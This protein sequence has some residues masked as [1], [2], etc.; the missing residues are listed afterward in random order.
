MTYRNKIYQ[1]IIGLLLI[2]L[3]SC[4]GGK[5]VAKQ[6]ISSVKEKKEME[7]T[8][9]FIEGNKLKTLGYL[10]EAIAAFSK[11]LEIKENSPAVNYELANLYVFNNKYIKAI[12][13]S[14]KAA[15]LNK[16][17][18]WYQLLYANL[19]MQNQEYAKS[20][21]VIEDLYKNNP[22]NFDILINLA[23]IY[24]TNKKDYSKALKLYNKAEEL[25]GISEEIY[26][27]KEKIYIKLGK[28][29][30][31]IKDLKNLVNA[32]PDNARYVGI[33]AETLMN[34]GKETEALEAYKKLFEIDPDN[35]IA[36]LSYGEFLL[37]TGKI[38][39]AIEEF[40]IGIGNQEVDIQ[41]KIELVIS[42]KN[43]YSKDINSDV[44][45]KLLDKINT[46]HPDR[47]EAFALKAELFL[48]ENKLKEAQSA[49]I[50]VV[51][52]SKD[53]Y[54]IWEQLILLDSELNEYKK[55][56]QHSK[57]AM[58][59]FPNYPKFILF[60]GYACQR[61]KKYDEGIANL[62]IGL[63]LVTKQDDLKSEFYSTLGELYFSAERFGESYKAF[64]EALLLNPENIIVL[65]NYSYYLALQETSLEKAK[66]MAGKV[67]ELEPNNSTYLDTYAWVLYKMNNI[68][69]ALKKIEL[70]VQNS[71][72]VSG[73]I[74]EHY[75]DILY[76]SGNTEKA[77]KQWKSARNRGGGSENL[78]M[79]I[80][81]GELIE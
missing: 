37:K 56:Y 80:E 22:D 62:E 7:Y 5:H 45:H 42:L 55:M 81:R 71:N 63:D 77:I 11:C 34:F 3:L 46:T 13:Y 65:N 26:F 10:Q 68:S 41:P 76:K 50:N 25:V 6:D 74:L 59:Y 38:S 78:D 69:E 20:V 60:N 12:E 47:Y 79:K 58:E 75:G 15:K 61:L 73:V 72:D 14:E 17:N 40:E 54:I 30:E 28:N 31:L 51:E 44:I 4:S 29:D 39:E 36:H 43:Y 19:L 64:D 24:S 48:K 2:I 67:I 49:M 35:A 66:E 18:I 23:D 70:A 33:Y 9:Y 32:N 16:N 57:E 52:K 1:T 21:D 8:H 53:S 27:R